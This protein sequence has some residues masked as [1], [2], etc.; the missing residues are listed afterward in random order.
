MGN[1]TARAFCASKLIVQLFFNSFKLL[2]LISVGLVGFIVT[3]IGLIWVKPKTEL[4]QLLPGLEFSTEQVLAI[5]SRT[6]YFAS[7]L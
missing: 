5:G 3:I 1:P 6:P 4:N 2:I 7:I